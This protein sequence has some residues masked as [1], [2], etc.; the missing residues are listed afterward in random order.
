MPDLESSEDFL[1]RLKL[2]TRSNAQLGNVYREVEAFIKS[3]DLRLQEY[4]ICTEA[5]LQGI[6]DNESS[7]K[8]KINAVKEVMLNCHQGTVNKI[9]DAPSKELE[10]EYVIR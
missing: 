2:M 4:Q 8:T 1:A 6:T 3:H 9:F 10:A 7:D 5:V